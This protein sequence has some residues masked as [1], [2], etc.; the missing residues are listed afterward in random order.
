[1]TERHRATL[2]LIPPPGWSGARVAPQHLQAADELVILGLCLRGQH[3]Q[4]GHAVYNRTRA[5]EAA[6]K[7]SQHMALADGIR[8]LVGE[9]LRF[10]FPDGE[11][12]ANVDAWAAVALECGHDAKWAAG[13]INSGYPEPPAWMTRSDVGAE[14]R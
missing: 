5:G 4:Y 13:W 2:L 6:V 7:E 8:S 12:R 14:P 10:V 9:R 11:R 3:A 1:M